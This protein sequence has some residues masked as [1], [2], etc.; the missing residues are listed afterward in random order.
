M[1][2]I[3]GNMLLLSSICLISLTN[4]NTGPTIHNDYY[5]V[6]EDTP[7]GALAFTIN[8]SDPENDTLTYEIYGVNSRYFSVDTSTGRVSVL[9]E[10]D[11]ERNSVLKIFVEVSDGVN[12]T[13]GELSII[14]LDANDNEPIFLEASYDVDVLENTPVGTSLFKVLATDDD[15]SNAGVVHYNIDAVTPEA[16]RNLFSIVS[17]TGEV[18]LNGSLIYTSLNQFYQ[19]KINATDGGGRCHYNSTTIL[20]NIVFSIITVVDVPDLDPKFIGL[21][22]VGDVVEHSS[23]GQTVLKVTAM[24]QDIG[25]NDEIIYSIEHTDSSGDGLFSISSDNGAI[26]VSSD[27]NRE[28]IGDIVI[29]TVKGTESQ[30]NIH[31]D[32]AS[33]TALVQINILD[34]NDNIPEFFECEDV[35][36]E[37]SCAKCSH[38]TVEVLEHSLDPISINMKVKDQDKDSKSQ[39]ILEGADKDVFSVEPKITMSD[40]F[41]QLRVK[42]PQNLDFEEKTQMV[43]QVIAIDDEE[44]SFSSSATVTIN[45]M[46]M[47]DVSPKFPQSTYRLN[48]SEHSPV[49]TTIA[50]ITA[51]DPDTMD[52]DRLTYKLLPPSILL[53][54]DVEQNSGSV[55]VKSQILLDRESRSLYTATLQAIDTEGKVG[56]AMLEITLTD[57]NDQPPVFNRESYPVSVDEGADLE[58]KIEATDADDPDTAN[59]QIVYHIMPSKYSGNFTINPDTGLLTNRAILNREAIDPNL[60]GKIKLNVTATDKGSPPLF[61]MVTVIITIQDVNDNK[62]EFNASSYTFQVREGDKGAHAGSVY[63]ED[64]DQT[65]YFNRISFSIIDGSFGSF[66]IRSF[67]DRQ[68]YRGDITVDP[69][70]EL[71][72]ESA[73]RTYVLQVEAAD[74]EQRKSVVRVEVNVLDVND[75]RPEFRPTG[76]FTVKENTTITEVIGNFTGYDKDGNHSLVYELESIKCIC[77]GSETPCDSFILDP[78]GDIRVNPEVTLDYEQCDQVVIEAQVVDVFTEKGENDSISTGKVVINIEDI[79]DNAPEFISSDSVFVVLSES[80]SKGTSVAEVT[81]TDRDSGKFKEIEFEVMSSQFEDTNN[82]ITEMKNL[83]DVITT[84]QKDLYVGIIQTLKELDTNLQGKYLVKVS[85][86][87][88]GGISTN[89]DLEIFNVAQSYKVALIFK[90]SEAEVEETLDDIVRSLTDATMAS[91]VIAD[92][93]PVSDSD[94]QD[95]RSSPHT[96]IEAYYIYTNGTALTKAEV[97]LKVVHEDHYPQLVALGLVAVGESSVDEPNTDPWRYILLGMMAGLVVLLVILTTSMMCTH[98]KY[99]RKL[100]AAKAMNTASMVTPDKGKSGP[101][102]PG[103]NKYTMEGANPVLNLNIDTAMALDMDDRSTDSDKIS[104]NSLD[105]SDDMTIPENGSKPDAVKDE[106][107][108][109]EYTEP[110]G[111]ALAQRDQKKV[112]VNPLMAYNNPGFSTTDL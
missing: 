68:G 67:L 61:A 17:M 33:A 52:K 65:A 50:S 26:V 1:E 20:S 4:A 36:D 18:R 46:D 3:T 79:N 89:T 96:V 2:G 39:L 84:Q 60:E 66:I 86:T 110:L 30:R 87:D 105:Y 44:P 7:I 80:A 99:K 41:V 83:F 78:N 97:E 42:Q 70:I 22:Y 54:F 12:I 47:N 63:A 100:K 14:L 75:E 76:P 92:I 109:P 5:E 88:P 55:Y 64:L 71:D 93:R 40:I 35:G 13:P 59:S 10:L 51:E 111:A 57:I 95:S 29:L 15:T 21:P 23:V 27:V 72:Y 81:A 53:Y 108:P 24:D 48:V 62:P 56:T 28:L 107:I 103:T 31:G 74:M 45:I 98:R 112:T 49:G 91:V 9:G 37:L 90:V 69:D 8:A 106:D 102:V 94:T 77:K 16:G 34:I 73:H 32:Y 85:A 43:L 82:A 101:V 11:R 104:L 38:F 58:V 19:L 25:V 6:C